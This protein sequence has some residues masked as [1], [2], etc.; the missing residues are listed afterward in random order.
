[1]LFLL[2]L[3]LYLISRTPLTEEDLQQC[4]ENE[5]QPNSDVVQLTDLNYFELT[6]QKDTSWLIELYSPLCSHCKR[7]KHAWEETA[8]NLKEQGG[9]FKVGRV[10]CKCEIPVCRPFALRNYPGIYLIENGEIIQYDSK[11]RTKESFIS[12]A[13]Q[14][15]SRYQ[16]LG[17]ET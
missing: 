11:R 3:F 17:F 13:K 16:N 14:V 15:S 4:R 10:D 12:W 5:F 1:M 2:I 6:S 9:F 8:T 7:M